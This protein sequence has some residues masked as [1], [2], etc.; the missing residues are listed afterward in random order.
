MCVRNEAKSF[1]SREGSNCPNVASNC[2]DPRRTYIRWP[3]SV[4]CSYKTLSGHWKYQPY[5]CCNLSVVCSI[6]R[7]FPD[8]FSVTNVFDVEEEAIISQARVSACFSNPSTAT[9]CGLIDFAVFITTKTF[10]P[11][12]RLSIRAWLHKTRASTT[13]VVRPYARTCSWGIGPTV[14]RV[15]CGAIIWGDNFVACDWEASLSAES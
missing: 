10:L 2:G 4:M 13:A 9:F 14:V 11:C 5:V 12:K 7:D 3:A 1:C 6:L 15:F 8:A